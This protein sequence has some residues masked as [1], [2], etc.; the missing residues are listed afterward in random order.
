MTRV[1]TRLLTP[2]CALAALFALALPTFGHGTA[3]AQMPANR[4]VQVAEAVMAGP[5]GLRD[6]A[7]VHG[8]TAD[9][10]S[11]T[12]RRGTND[13][14]CISDNPTQNGWSVACYPT[15]IEPYM[16]RGRELSAQG[17]TDSQER[18]R[19]R[20][21]EADA[22]TLAMPEDPATVYI[23]VGDGFD[24]AKGEV[25]NSFLRWAIYVPWATPETTGLS[26]QPLSEGAPWLM[27]PGTAGAH[28]MVTPP[29]SGS[30]D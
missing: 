29:R 5:A 22:G 10:R 19:I 3:S 2:L 7:T 27:F 11:V 18:L 23:L 30:R 14:V 9:G 21:A 16:V 25:L 24:A 17:V 1:A 12:L 8:W 26:P 6:G 13:L 20:W 4:D 28:I 15:S